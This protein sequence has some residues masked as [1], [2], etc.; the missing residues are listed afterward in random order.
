MWARISIGQEWKDGKCIR[1]ARRL[2][3]KVR[4]KHVKTLNSQTMMTEIAYN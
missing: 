3:G 2:N 1:N 4:K